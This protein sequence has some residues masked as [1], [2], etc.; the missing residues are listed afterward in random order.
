[1]RKRSKSITY[2][3]VAKGTEVPQRITE[4]DLESARVF[5]GYDWT[6]KRTLYD[7]DGEETGEI[8]ETYI[9]RASQIESAIES[10]SHPHYLRESMDT[11]VIDT[12]TSKVVAVVS[13]DV[14]VVRR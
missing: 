6:N 11:W 3:Y 1:M 12:Y 14:T 10:Q 2:I 7:E 5:Y 13:Y 9:T 4:K 8:E